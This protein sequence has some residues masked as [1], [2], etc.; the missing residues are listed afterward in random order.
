MRIVLLGAP[1]SGKGT[2]SQRLRDRFRIP[3]VSTGD[4]LRDAVARGTPLGLHAK[5]VM[6][7]GKLVHD[8]TVLGIIHERLAEPD[9]AQGFILDGFPRTLVQAEALTAMLAAAGT[10]LDAVVLLNVDAGELVRRIAGRRSCRD[11]GKVFNVFTAPPAPD[12]RCPKAAEPHRL[13]QRPDDNEAT[14]AKRLQVYEEQ[15]KPLVAYYRERGLLHTLDADQEVDE[16]SR[17]LIEELS[18]LHVPQDPVAA[19]P[20]AWSR[21]RTALTARG[22]S[23]Q[24]AKKSAR[25]RSRPA[26]RKSA[27]AKPRRSKLLRK[28]KRKTAA[29]KRAARRPSRTARSAR[30]RRHR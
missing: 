3:Q 20:R 2:Q 8:Q 25:L 26:G 12:E 18:A 14:V 1:G 24:R 29:A 13:M 9:A 11:C 28:P 22:R 30:P 21:G 17:R 16:V 10:P 27:A 4:L 6:D 15:T 7:A 23:Q 5:A 19:P